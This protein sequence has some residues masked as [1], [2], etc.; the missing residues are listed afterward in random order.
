VPP[1]GGYNTQVIQRLVIAPK[2]KR[3][4]FGAQ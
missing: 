3:V 2:S 4:G 1:R